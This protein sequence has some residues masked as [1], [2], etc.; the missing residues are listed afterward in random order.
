MKRK[1]VYLFLCLFLC[2]FLAGCGSTEPEETEEVTPVV[3]AVP[4]P[5][6]PKPAPDPAPAV[7]D[8]S[9]AQAEAAKKEA[10]AK[11]IAEARDAAVKAGAADLLPEEL[12]VI[13]EN[14]SDVLESA[15]YEAAAEKAA[16]YYKALEKAAQGYAL[17]N[18][19]IEN[20]YD[21][22]APEPF[23]KANAAVDELVD[24]WYADADISAITA[25]IDE[26][27]A[28]LEQ[29][30]K[31]GYA[32]SLLHQAEQIERQVQYYRNQV[33]ET[34]AVQDYPEYL[35][36]VDALADLARS[37]YQE[38][39]NLEA[40]KA[41]A[42]Y[43]IAGYKALV[44]AALAEEAYAVICENGWEDRDPERFESGLAASE[45]FLALAEEDSDD[46]QAYLEH[47]AIAHACFQK[48]VDD[49][50]KNNADA[51]RNR[52]VDV[53]KKADAIKANV[54]AKTDYAAATKLLL[55][56]DGSASR[57]QWQK[58]CGEYAA[59]ADAMTAVYEAVSVKRNAA[60]EAMDKAKRKTAEVDE[61]A[62][63]AD[64]VAPLSDEEAM[65]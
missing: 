33:L 47:A 63:Q 59:A 54:A 43:V 38:T 4:E 31:D 5:A 39:G 14:A 27:Y 24:L 12:A 61:L 53:K 55:D 57:G 51:E 13:D 16:A 37:R 30:R 48:I 29:T 56:A 50:F 44:E 49:T 19:I 32:E 20:G 28:L 9:A 60:Q 11:L 7:Q 45:A 35:A 2:L 26:V 17:Y 36:K 34:S 8:D 15:D 22:Y 21:A 1:L 42:D 58:A 46:M 25:K 18:E 62:V 10:A 41:D 3:E 65:E 40:L 64:E 6:A 23:D 52:Y